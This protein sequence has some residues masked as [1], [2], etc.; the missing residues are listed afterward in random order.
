M[1]ETVVLQ[2]DTL[3]ERVDGVDEVVVEVHFAQQNQL[4]HTG[5][6]YDFVVIQH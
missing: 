3:W 5:I 1:V 4:V 6:V 2:V